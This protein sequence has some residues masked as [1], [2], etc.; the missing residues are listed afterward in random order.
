[1]TTTSLAVPQVPQVVAGGAA[2]ES[3]GQKV[4]ATVTREDNQIVVQAG[5]VTAKVAGVNE[6]G[7]PVSLDA[8]GNIRI[9]AGSR[10]RIRASGFEPG[11]TVDGWLFST[12]VRIGSATVDATG[13]VDTTFVIPAGTPAGAHRIVIEARTADGKPTTIA[14]GL[15]I[16]DFDKESNIATRLIIAALVLAILLAIL[17]PAVSRR[18]PGETD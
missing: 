7:E 3:D 2:V 6:A 11:S 9:P 14:V 1:M 18:R 5:P 8:D 13:S 4:P 10:V 15:R 12:P 16:G 17:L